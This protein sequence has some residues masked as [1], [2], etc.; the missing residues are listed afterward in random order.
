MQPRT[1]TTYDAQHPLVL[2]ALADWSKVTISTGEQ[3]WCAMHGDDTFDI[4]YPRSHD[5]SHDNRVDRLRIL[6]ISALP[7]TDPDDWI[8]GAEDR[9]KE[10]EILDDGKWRLGKITKA[11]ASGISVRFHGDSWVTHLPVTYKFR[12][13]QPAAEPTA[14]APKPGDTRPREAMV[15]IPNGSFHVNPGDT[16]WALALPG[17]CLDNGKFSLD[18]WSLV[19]WPDDHDGMVITT[20]QPYWHHL[21]AVTPELPP[22]ERRE[23]WKETAEEEVAPPVDGAGAGAGVEM[24]T[25]ASKWETKQLIQ[26][27]KNH[28]KSFRRNETLDH[29]EMMRLM[30]PVV[31]RIAVLESA[32]SALAA[33][34]KP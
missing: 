7:Q 8:V 22:S 13:V 30:A 24:P 32:L 15:P 23:W 28:A 4:Q 34:E 31:T 9:G 1:I 21:P 3:Y 29:E 25:L 12:P 20:T 27:L 6:P 10:C 18:K 17:A 33:K 11:T 19:E 14:P 16:Y 5:L 26:C 2:K